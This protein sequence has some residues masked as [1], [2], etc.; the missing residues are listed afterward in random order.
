[1]SSLSLLPLNLILSRFRSALKLAIDELFI[2]MGPQCQT[3]AFVLSLHI[4]AL[5]DHVLCLPFSKLLFSYQ[6]YSALTHV[7]VRV[8][9]ALFYKKYWCYCFLYEIIAATANLSGTNLQAD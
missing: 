4:S 5:L 9:N 8:I 1:M 2:A 6:P 7:C 3:V